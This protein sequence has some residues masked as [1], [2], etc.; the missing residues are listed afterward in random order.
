MKLVT[1][2]AVESIQCEDKDKIAQVLAEEEKNKLKADPCRN[3]STV[4][5]FD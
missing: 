4:L 3:I 5:S 2:F 1:A